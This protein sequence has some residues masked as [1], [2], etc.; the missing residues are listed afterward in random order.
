M[1]TVE[2]LNDEKT[3]FFVDYGAAR[4]VRYKYVEFSS[5]TPEQQSL[6]F[7]LKSY[8]VGEV[9]ATA[10]R[11]MSDE[12]VFKL[13]ERLARSFC[14]MYSPKKSYGLDKSIIRIHILWILDELYRQSK[15][16]TD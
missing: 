8:V 15:E 2:Y 5:L 7:D 14:G 13:V 4:R 10:L 1:V 12:N 16:V 11:N 9:N 3:E 6:L